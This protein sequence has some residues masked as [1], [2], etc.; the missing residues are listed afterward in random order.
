MRAPWFFAAVLPG[1][2]GG[3][4]LRGAMLLLSASL[5]ALALG[6]APAP[7]AA[8]ALGLLLRAD[9]AARVPQANVPAGAQA[10][11]ARLRV[12]WAAI[13]TR[14]G[15]YDWTQLDAAVTALRAGGYRVA[16]ALVGGN[17]LYPGAERSASPLL[18][19][20]FPAWLAF[21]RGAADRFCATAEVFEIGENPQAAGLDA[22]SFALL[23]KQSALAVRAR[24]SA[25]GRDVAVAPAASPAADRAWLEG[26]WAR[27]LA[28][29]VDVL[30]LR[31]DPA[32]AP[33][34]AAAAV[35]ATRLE[36]LLHPPAATIWAYVPGTRGWDAP[37]AATAALAAGAAAALFEPGPGTAER[38]RWAQALQAL[39]GDGY[40]P[41][42]PGD[43]RLERGDG[44]ARPA[45]EVLGRFFRERDFTTLVVF[46]T[47]AD[48]GEPL[49]LVVDASTVRNARIVDLASGSERRVASEPAPGGAAE[50]VLPLAPSP[51]PAAAV[52]QRQAAAPGL[53]LPPEELEIAST[54]ALTAEEIIS[55]HQQVQRVQ[56][57]RLQRFMA[58]GRIDFHFRLTQGSGVDVSIDSNYFWERGGDLEWEQTEYYINGNR[59]RWKSIPQLPLIQPEKVITLPLDLTL[60][61]TYRYRLVGE[62]RVA[63]RAAYVLEFAPADPDSPLDLYRGRVWIDKES[64]T[65]LKT[66]LIQGGLEPPVLSNEEVDRFAPQ[67]G[68]DGQD[69]WMFDKIDGQQVWNTAGR[70][71]VVRREVTFTEYRINPDAAEF[72]AARARA[73][74]SNNQ[75]LR[76]T[77]EGFRYLEPQPDGGRT[78]KT[79]VDTSQ[80]FAAGGAFKDDSVSGVV[81]LAGVN[82]FDYDVAGKNV[83]LNAL[84]AGVFAFVT[85]SKPDLW[86]GAADLT[87]DATLSA[88]KTDD[89]VYAGDEEILIER[90]RRRS[91]SLAL[92]FGIPL[93][94]FFKLSL[95]GRT[96]FNEFD[97][98]EDASAALD[99]LNARLDSSLELV[100][101]QDHVEWAGELETVFNRRGWTLSAWGKWAERSDWEAWGLRDTDSGRFV[102]SEA[103]EDSYARWEL[104]AAKEWY[105]PKFQKLRLGFDAL[106]GA[107]LDRFSRYTF[108]F[109]G[110]D[111]LNGFS[112][113]GVRF[114][115]GAIARAGYSFNLFEAVRFNATLES[116]RVEREE[117]A[118]GRQSFSGIGI[119]ADF[120]APWKT[121]VNFSYGYALASDI[122]D[123]EGQQEFLLLIF[124]LF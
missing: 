98:N 12:E 49:R 28:A 60:N 19:Q 70:T 1:E 67:T 30:P 65:R 103:L 47:S 68:P 92:R 3:S 78:V 10:P 45:G 59:V 39:L 44:G 84:F 110:E 53:E 21:V 123:L 33:A 32:S 23:V 122:P 4:A 107:H 117:S 31:L 36:S 20:A 108:G 54:R 8:P 40:A 62:E 112:G 2:R 69:Y 41:A 120:V 52:F 80:L 119:S 26:M 64:F 7:P 82:Y 100:V 74:A 42:P 27:D 6:A 35:Q 51:A 95:I 83:Q 85:A 113:S 17:P 116:A 55:R 77:S 97:D 86:G 34:A 106:D 11:V 87:A 13:E 81:P 96:T 124:K 9:E 56:D 109:F 91:Q 25:A 15:E 75:M 104:S 18:A 99:R 102:V 5:A 16:L 58:R 88:L 24:A 79:K 93:G 90:L 121:V 63:D 111:R 73:Y 118:E 57:D 115:R 14:A 89:K 72:A 38:A 37:A 29:Y 114:D 43:L 22:D 105:L 66:S 48:A 76:D 50:R 46:R 61:R 94:Q 101:P 71:F